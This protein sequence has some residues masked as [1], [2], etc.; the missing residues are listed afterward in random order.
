[1]VLLHAGIFAWNLFRS[2]IIV[3]LKDLLGVQEA[4][5]CKEIQLLFF[6]RNFEQNSHCVLEVEAYKSLKS[7]S[8]IFAESL[9]PNDFLDFFS[10]YWRSACDP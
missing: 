8:S 9:L 5:K 1:M 4:E 3:V 10:S 6:E 2:T 7:L